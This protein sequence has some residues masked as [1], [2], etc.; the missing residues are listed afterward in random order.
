MKTMLLAGAALAGLLAAATA[1][2]AAEPPQVPKHE[3]DPKPVM[4][5][6]TM[7]Q[8]P[9]VVRRLQRD[10]DRYRECMKS[11]ADERS[12]H[13]KAH[14]DAGNAA[15]NEYNATMKE[16]QEAQKGQ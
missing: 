4:P 3:C 7:R 5:G 11:Y 15:I 8:D 9:M 13:S 1:S 12:A 10:I 14:T 6:P 2:T 16:L